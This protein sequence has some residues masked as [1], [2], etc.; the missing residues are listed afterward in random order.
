MNE[1]QKII[2]DIKRRR[3][4]EAYIVF[5]IGIVLFIYSSI[6]P[7]VD[8]KTFS[9]VVLA[10]ISSLVYLTIMERRSN[11][12]PIDIEGIAWFR[13]NRDEIPPF[14]KTFNEAKKEII[15][16]SVQ[17]NSIVHNHLG[18]L[19][20]KAE[21]GVKIKILLMAARLPNGE[22]NPNVLQTQ[23]LRTFT[24]LLREIE[25]NTENLQKWWAELTPAVQERV[26]IHNYQYFCPATYT[27]IDKDE[28]HG[29]V[30]VEILH[31]G[32]DKQYNPHFV[33]KKKDCS[34]F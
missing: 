21:S 24:G 4:I 10:G 8:Q 7:E 22:E 5:I 6:V 13:P 31:Y 3:Y 2:F 19:K 26:E 18:L 11:A 23:H 25:N 14:I 20:E 32:I 9:Q 28:P 16:V 34:T 33:V 29:Y 15:A 1:F 17:H 27:F 30:V 12:S